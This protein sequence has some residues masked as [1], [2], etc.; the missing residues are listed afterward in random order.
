MIYF[1]LLVFLH[2]ITFTCASSL[3]CDCGYFDP[4]T[5]ATW[6]NFYHLNFDKRH[7]F[8]NHSVLYNSPQDLFFANYTIP[9]KYNDTYPR[10]FQRDNIR[11]ADDSLEI[12]ITTDPIV[13]CGGVGTHRQ[14]FL[15][16]SFRTYLKTTTVKGT[17]SAFYIFNS[18]TAELDI[19]ILSALPAPH[20]V[21]FAIHP[22]LFDIHGRASS[23]THSSA[24]L[25]FGGNP[26]DGFHE[27]RVDWF[28]N[29]VVFYLDGQEAY[30]STTNVVKV[31][32]RIMLNHWTDGNPNFSQGPA[33]QNASL[34][35]KNMTFFFNDSTASTNMCILTNQ[36]CNIEDIVRSIS[37][38]SLDNNAPPYNDT[39]LPLEGEK[40]SS[41]TTTIVS[42]E[43]SS[44]T[45]PRSS[46]SCLTI[47]HL[48]LIRLYFILCVMLL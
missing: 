16:G 18:V 7:R 24:V 46:S 39:L 2:F 19:E 1:L 9:A 33:Q 15:F 28:P 47:S 12:I 35:I 44:F 37:N 45:P 32:S 10:V 26:T 42:V 14:D 38:P 43:T 48:N 13:Q 22:K 5:N 21:Y 11:L 34:L 36:Q 6:A 3:D 29:L 25:P 41:T 17:V 31:P 30:R 23:E 8:A 4:T 20:P 27:Y 40:E